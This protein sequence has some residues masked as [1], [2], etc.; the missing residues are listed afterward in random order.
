MSKNIGPK[1]KDISVFP[2]AKLKH[3]LVVLTS[4]FVFC[5]NKYNATG[6]IF[7]YNSNA[8]KTLFGNLSV[9]ISVLI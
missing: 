3:F 9:K 6:V 2:S 8:V 1:P 5:A 4:V 7:I